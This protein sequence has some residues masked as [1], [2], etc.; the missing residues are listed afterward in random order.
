LFVH[1]VD[2]GSITNGAQRSHIALAS[3]SARVRGMEQALGISLL[4]R[5]RRGVKPT[6]AGRAVVEHARVIL[7]QLDRMRGDLSNYARGLKGHVR[8]LT[9][10]AAI[11]EYLPQ[12]LGTFLAEHP[13]VDIDLEERVSQD[14]VAAVSSGSADMGIV[15]ESVDMGA[16]EAIPFRLDRLVVVTALNHPLARRR[17]VHFADVVDHDFIGLVEGAALQEYLAA[18]A[19]REGKRLKYRARLP[20]FDAVCRMVE[21]GAGVGLLPETAADRCRSTMSIRKVRL[22]DSWAMRRLTICVRRYE[23]MQP[24]AK[25]V[26]E[27]IRG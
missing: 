9:N 2:A 27:K 10:T 15:T 23:T 19:V 24:F 22:A 25:L 1:V 8:I 26:V 13:N 20:S 5:G 16:L 18:K 12:A 7:H 3:A 6:A 14:I 4:A 11:S 21:C 17:R